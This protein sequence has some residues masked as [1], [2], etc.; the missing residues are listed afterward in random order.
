MKKYDN[1]KKALKNLELCENYAPPYDVVIMTGLVN[2]FSICF[3]QS[4]KTMKEILEKQGFSQG[5]TGSPKMIIKLA[6]SAH[7]IQDEAGWLE[8][9]NDRNEIAH[10]YNEKIA[11]SIIDKVKERHLHL[12]QKLD[13]EIREN[14]L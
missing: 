2:L 5:K 4:W 7:M 8:L 10:S 3:E 12:F 13:H 6:Y 1:F 14:W 9:L 11:F